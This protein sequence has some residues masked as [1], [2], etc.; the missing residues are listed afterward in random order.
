MQVPRERERPTGR[1]TGQNTTLCRKS[2]ERPHPPEDPAKAH[3]PEADKWQGRTQGSSH[4][5]K[6]DRPWSR[7]PRSRGPQGRHRSCEYPRHQLTRQQLVKRAPHEAQR[8]PEEGRADRQT[9]PRR[10]ADLVG[11]LPASRSPA[12][13]PSARRGSANS[14]LPFAY[15]KHFKKSQKRKQE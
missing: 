13:L 4:R 2:R 10:H 14:D 7:R 12:F 1:L 5:C 9:L 11:S 8:E 6:E 15:N 3:Q